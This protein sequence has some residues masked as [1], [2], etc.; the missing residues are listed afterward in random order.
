M[1]VLDMR[2]LVACIATCAV[3]CAGTAQVTYRQV[4]ACNGWVSGDVTHSAGPN[5]AYTV[6]QVTSV[7]NSNGKA[8]FTLDPSK[9]AVNAGGAKPLSAALTTELASAVKIAPLS[10]ITVAAGQK[11]SASGYGVAVVPTVNANGAVEANATSY[12]LIY[13]GTSTD[14][15]VLLTKQDPGR[16]SWPVTE[17]CKK[18]SY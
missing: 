12:F 4:G 10:P 2:Y 7:D 8:A 15:G 9:L 17:D 3:G 13:Q 6:F 18:I 16:T 11:Q 1:E 14:P 5:A